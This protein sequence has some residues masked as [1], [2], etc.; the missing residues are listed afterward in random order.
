MERFNIYY[1]KCDDRWEGRISRGRRK[2]GKRRFKYIFGHS[3]EEVKSK[4]QKLLLNEDFAGVSLMY[5]ATHGEEDKKYMPTP[6][7]EE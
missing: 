7:D 1:R 6:E 3:K 4:I 2:N 5:S